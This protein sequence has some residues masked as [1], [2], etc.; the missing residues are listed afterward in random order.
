MSHRRGAPRERRLSRRGRVVVLDCYTRT[1]LAVANA[2]GGRYELIG[3]TPQRPGLPAAVDRLLSSPRFRA[4]FRYPSAAADPAGF[5]AA[6]AGACRRFGADAVFPAS[7]LTALSLARLRADGWDEAA[8]FVCEQREKLLAMAD[9]WRFYQLCRRSGIPTPRTVVPTGEGLE[10]LSELSFPLVWKPRLL[11]SGR[12][13]RILRRREELDQLLLSAPTPPIG[14]PGEYPY[15]VQEYVEGTIQDAVGCFHEGRPL[16]L[17][18]HSRL[19]TQFDF[20]G[21][22]VVIETSHERDL[23]AVARHLARRTVWSGPALF[24]FIRKPDGRPVLLECNPRVWGSTQLTVAAGLNV[25]QQAVDLFV[26]R[27]SPEPVHDYFVGLVWKWLTLG[28]L[29]SCIRPGDPAAGLARARQLLGNGGRPTV[30]NLAA[31]DLPHLAGMFAH[32][33]A[34]HAHRLVTHN[35]RTPPLART[36]TAGQAPPAKHLDR[37]HP[38]SQDQ[39]TK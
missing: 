3:G 2:L 9:K 7:T 26:H 12:G 14:E 16:S 29:A 25:C 34:A 10:R 30:T 8:T 33:A 39:R 20:G 17:A 28:S 22:G 24:E 6:L 15:I 27:R 4:V 1:G 21:P 13:V 32:N 18:T 5:A 38:S 23:M 11:E 35:G 31:D 37:A 19:A 36:R